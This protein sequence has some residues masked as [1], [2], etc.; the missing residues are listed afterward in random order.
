M[1]HPSLAEPTAEA[2]RGRFLG[3][4]E[5]RQRI[6]SALGH[7]TPAEFEQQW[8]ADPTGEPVVL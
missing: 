2:G 1:R 6:H 3:D 4:V 7:L 8:R 5:N